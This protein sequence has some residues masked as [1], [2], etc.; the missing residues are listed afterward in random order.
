MPIHSFADLSN[1]MCL[2][3]AYYETLLAPTTLRER[4]ITSYHAYVLSSLKQIIREGSKELLP[5][6]L[7]KNWKI[8]QRTSL[9]YTAIP[10]DAITLLLC[11]VA[12][13]LQ[14]SQQGALNLLMPTVNTESMDDKYPHLGCYMD[15]QGQTRVATVSLAQIL[16]THILGQERAYLIP[17]DYLTQIKTGSEPILNFYYDY[18]RHHES[19]V[20][21]LDTE[22]EKLFM[23]SSLTQALKQDLQAYEAYLTQDKSLLTHV[24]RL[25][26]NLLFNSVHG[27]GQETN[28][29]R[30]AYAAII[31]FND[32][33]QQLSDELRQKIPTALK[34]ELTLL[35]ELASNPKK[36]LTP[37]GEV[38]GETCLGTRSI[39]LKKIIE[40]H[41]VQL[42]E[43][44]ADETTHTQMLKAIKS[45]IEKS[46]EI[47]QMQL[48][49][50][51]YQGREYLALT[52]ELLNVLNLSFSIN[53]EHD[54]HDFMQLEAE[55]IRHFLETKP[56]LC[57]K[58]LHQLPTLESLCI[59]CIENKPEK[60][61]VIFPSIAPQLQ[62]KF[63]DIKNF[64]AFLMPLDPYRCEA[65]YRA[66]HR[67][68]PQIAPSI[69]TLTQ[70]FEN[71]SLE[72]SRF[73]KD[74]VQA[75]LL[76]MAREVDDLKSILMYFPVEHYPSLFNGLQEKLPQLIS[77][78]YELRSVLPHFPTEHY[79]SL[80]NNL[81]EKLPQLICSSLE[82]ARIFDFLNE[83]QSTV[84][85]NVLTK[86]IEKI[87]F[88]ARDVNS[89]LSW[90]KPERRSQA[91]QAM[92]STL[93][94]K[95]HSAEDFNAILQRL[96]ITERH[97]VYEMAKHM[98][99][100]LIQSAHD[101]KCI[102]KFLSPEER[103]E[104]YIQIQEK[105][106]EPTF[107][108]TAKNFNWVLKYLPETYRTEVYTQKLDQLL[109]SSPTAKTLARI[110][111]Y[112]NP[113]QSIYICSQLNISSQLSL[114][115]LDDFFLLFYM[116]PAKHLGI[117][118]GMAPEC[119]R[120]VVKK[121]DS[122]ENLTILDELND[123][124]KTRIFYHI[125]G[126]HLENL[127]KTKQDLY[128]LLEWTD[129]RLYKTIC[130]TLKRLP[131]IVECIDDFCFI[132]EE[133]PE[134]KTTAFYHAITLP[135]LVKMLKSAEDFNKLM[136]VLPKKQRHRLYKSTKLDFIPNVI[137]DNESF[138]YV[139]YRLSLKQRNE[140]YEMMKPRLPHLIHTAYD[141]RNILLFLNPDQCFRLCNELDKKILTTILQEEYSLIKLLS[142][143]NI[144]QIKA[145]LPVLGPL[146]PNIISNVRL[147]LN[148]C[149]S[150]W[151]AEA[152][153]CLLQAYLDGLQKQLHAYEHHTFY[154]QLTQAAADYF[155]NSLT[156]AEFQQ[157]SELAIQQARIVFNS[158]TSLLALISK[159]LVAV[160]SLG[161]I[162]LASTIKS[163]YETGKWQCRF[164]AH[165]MERAL[166]HWEDTETL[167]LE[168][169]TFA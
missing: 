163:R 136:A 64:I 70:L 66:L 142:L 100:N 139:L 112:L 21:L 145:M 141:L 126:D 50:K 83:E 15:E 107:I 151:T 123:L 149:V 97:E 119:M 158:Q 37:T 89:F 6:F 86:V 4:V 52:P 9:C 135:M 122:V 24:R 127:I 73:L 84:A 76:P 39:E 71:L 91:Y 72:Q 88:S 147:E 164:F 34:N 58:I 13:W 101:F 42:S 121:I 130:R 168:N 19:M 78:I 32:Y 10:D 51:V 82:L 20:Y 59:F 129:P 90:L 47:I 162:L 11:D 114:N 152:A 1:Q 144:Y 108:A 60:I 137:N 56:L 167:L 40:A 118:C 160:I 120:K 63:F 87:I 80:F 150:I 109:E 46:Q 116:L 110:L 41:E 65:V 12:E 85:F 104:V 55:E 165:P 8:I 115:S 157:A 140:V 128:S 93:T 2:L 106:N 111:C 134:R 36:N 75:N 26:R 105:L 113:E 155:S 148:S 99:P 138:Q 48:Q 31:E 7:A 96:S 16:K 159:W 143:L 154:Q 33:Y 14:S 29:G 68:L 23:H 49:Q 25:Q 161:T 67:V 103:M 69:Y 117:V 131:E 125:L 28:A 61:E 95:I 43:L 17:I 62:Q 57:E 166:E 35:L 98:V 54:F 156:S 92:R 27:I 133:L 81:E 124:E 22:R 44:A 30:F 38:N 153:K 18:Q 45:T 102:L 3:E 146:L 5:L 169:P 77:S 132:H 53:D 94:A 74:L 79:P